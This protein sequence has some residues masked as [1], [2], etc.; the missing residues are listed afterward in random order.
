MQDP[1]V[2]VEDYKRYRDSLTDVNNI[3]DEIHKR[4]DLKIEEVQNQIAFK[5][6][7]HQQHLSHLQ[8][9]LEAFQETSIDVEKFKESV[10]SRYGMLKELDS[11]PRPELKPVSRDPELK[12][13]TLNVAAIS[14]EGN[15]LVSNEPPSVDMDEFEREISEAFDGDSETQQ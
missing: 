11:E 12:E 1:N 8:A 9:T 6:A 2:S 15:G 7:S 3:Q 5:I 14:T 10:Q 13:N 4:L